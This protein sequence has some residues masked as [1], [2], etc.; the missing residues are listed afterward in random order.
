MSQDE[1]NATR[2]RSK[3]TSENSR[4]KQDTSGIKVERR[5]TLYSRRKDGK[6]VAE[7]ASGFSGSW[8]H[9]AVRA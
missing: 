7:R 4:E 3:K 9:R 1:E 8:A 5:E 6:L 2:R